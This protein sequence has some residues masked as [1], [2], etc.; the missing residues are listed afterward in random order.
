MGQV[1][2]G[3]VGGGG[4]GGDGGGCGVVGDEGEEE[5]VEEVRWLKESFQRFLPLPLLLPIT[6]VNCSN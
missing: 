4:N 3:G 1:N 6:V 2:S 5:V